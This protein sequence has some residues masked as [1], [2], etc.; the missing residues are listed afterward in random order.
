MSAT[1]AVLCKAQPVWQAGFA[2]NR[3]KKAPVKHQRPSA[4]NAADNEDKIHRRSGLASDHTRIRSW[5]PAKRE[6]PPSSMDWSW[7]PD[8]NYTQKRQ[9]A[10]SNFLFLADSTLLKR[11]FCSDAIGEPF[12]ESRSAL[13]R[14]I[15]FLTRS[16]IKVLYWRW[17]FHEEPST[18]M[19]TFHWTKVP[20]RFFKW[21]KCS[22]K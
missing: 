7:S 13:K 18:S 20:K 9:G 1:A 8:A 19:E 11:V 16:N 6:E 21:I 17:C 15:F 3:P 2:W 22:S 10:F 12:F 4:Q 5:S 14:T